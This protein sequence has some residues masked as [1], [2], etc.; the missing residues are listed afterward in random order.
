MIASMAIQRAV[1]KILISCFLSREL[2]HDETNRAWWTGVS[3][4][5]L[6]RTASADLPPLT[7]VVESRTGR[8]SLVAARS[9]V[10]RQDCRDVSLLGRLPC[11]GESSR[12][13]MLAERNK[14][15]LLRRA[16]SSPV[17]PHTAMPHPRHR[18]AAF[19]DALCVAIPPPVELQLISLVVHSL[20]PSFE[21]DPKSDLLLQAEEAPTQDHH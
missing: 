19:D 5:S 1:F 2:K 9:R 21:A 14:L 8:R 11:R 7:E 3:R 20:A 16:A 13:W 4:A 10:C 12:A 6:H 18:H 15:T 17:H